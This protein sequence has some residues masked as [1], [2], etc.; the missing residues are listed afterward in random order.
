MYMKK[1]KDTL[2]ADKPLEKPCSAVIDAEL[3]DKIKA[4]AYWERLPLKKVIADAIRA[5]IAEYEK[6]NGEV[7]PIPEM[8]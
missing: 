7:K 5:K 6:E 1:G 4:I 2:K 8:E 3:T